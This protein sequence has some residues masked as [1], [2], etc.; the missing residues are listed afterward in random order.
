VAALTLAAEA[1]F[2]TAANNVFHLFE[3]ATRVRLEL[4]GHELTWRRLLGERLAFRLC[5]TSSFLSRQ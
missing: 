5:M 1:G 3:E 2:A 4:I